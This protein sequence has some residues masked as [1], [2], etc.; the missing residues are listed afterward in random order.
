MQTMSFFLPHQRNNE[1]ATKSFYST[2]W[3]Y[4][5]CHFDKKNRKALSHFDG[6]GNIHDL[7]SN[8]IMFVPII[9]IVQLYLNTLSMS[10]M[11]FNT[12]SMSNMKFNTLSMSKY[13]EQFSWYKKS[14]RDERKVL[15]AKKY[16]SRFRTLKKCWINLTNNRANYYGKKN[17]NGCRSIV[18]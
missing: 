15:G 16:S 4:M 17:S 3:F 14:W 6:I 8:Y 7:F 5:I 11:K 9:S 2:S 10:N 18:L 12:L 1:I 13:P